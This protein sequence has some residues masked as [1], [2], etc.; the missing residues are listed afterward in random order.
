MAFTTS[1]Q[2]TEWAYSYSPGAHTGQNG[3]GPR[4][5]ERY[6]SGHTVCDNV[7]VV[8]IAPHSV[9]PSLTPLLPS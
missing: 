8:C 6:G 9:H 2:E 3:L 1:G 7:G 4:D 5:I